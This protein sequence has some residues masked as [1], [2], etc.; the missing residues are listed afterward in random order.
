MRTFLRTAALAAALLPQA[1]S[2]PA[3]AAE[4][5]LKPYVLAYVS[6]GTIESEL[7]RVKA[8]LEKEGFQAAGEYSPYKGVRVLAVTSEELKTNAA[9]SD[10]G[11][12]GAAVRV[13]LTETPSGLQVSYFNP[14]Y[15]AQAYRM[16]GDLSTVAAE[17]EKALGREQDFG[18]GK[19]L[20][21]AKLRKYH[22][23]IAMP[24]FTSQ[25]ELAK[26]PGQAAALKAVEEGLAAHRGGTAEVYRVDVPG[27]DESLIGVAI[28][29][30]KGSDATVMAATDRAEL[31][32]SA[33]LPYELV[34]SGGKV[35][36]LPGK[37]RIALDFPDLTMGTFMKISGAPG[38][39]EQALKQAANPEKNR[40]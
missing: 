18:S 6:T 1:L 5:A 22:Y 40:K 9:K 13:A 4:T 11:A 20:K 27:K 12:Y 30:G 26:Y 16:A 35:Y 34:V 36:M 24:H 14:L 7:P 39:I 10:F 17:L 37:F 38:A 23:M 21:P 32:H 33:H 28:T 19:G 31:K 29:E 25:V 15:M 3:A 2:S 8:A